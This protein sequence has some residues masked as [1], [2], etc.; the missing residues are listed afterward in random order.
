MAHALQGA[1][2]QLLAS[3]PDGAASGWRGSEAA[4]ESSY[5]RHGVVGTTIRSAGKATG[6]V[7]WT[8]SF[9]MSIRN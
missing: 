7:A 1:A 2:P 3:R 8:T 9:N 6:E 5:P 4:A